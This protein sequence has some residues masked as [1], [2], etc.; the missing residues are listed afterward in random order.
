MSPRPNNPKYCVVVLLVTCC[1]WWST[2]T[3]AYRI[4]QPYNPWTRPNVGLDDNDVFLY[5]YYYE[6]PQRQPPF[7]GNDFYYRAPR[8]Q[9]PF[10]G[11]DFYYGAPRRQLPFPGNDFY[12]G[13]PRRHPYFGYVQSSTQDG[14]PTDGYSN[15]MSITNDLRAIADLYLLEQHRRREWQEE[16]LRRR[17]MELGK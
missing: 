2:M 15:R 14:Y 4:P 13:A 12:Y 5:D 8:R 16:N 6:A 17:F 1:C 9:P 3:D 10:P 11:N 7:H